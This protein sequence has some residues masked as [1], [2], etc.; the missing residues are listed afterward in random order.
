MR[1]CVHP[2]DGCTFDAAAAAVIAAALIVA[3]AAVAGFRLRLD[4]DLLGLWSSIDGVSLSL[5][6]SCSY[7][8]IS[9]IHPEKKT[10]RDEKTMILFVSESQEEE[11]S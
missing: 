11:L 4:L 7:R 6:D 3:A 2:N 9:L 1:T 8:A 10:E 5:R